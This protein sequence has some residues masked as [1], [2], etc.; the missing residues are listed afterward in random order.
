MLTKKSGYEG[1]QARRQQIPGMLKADGGA[2]KGG[3]A[4]PGPTRRGAGEVS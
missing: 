2:R 3:G 1:E 4:Q